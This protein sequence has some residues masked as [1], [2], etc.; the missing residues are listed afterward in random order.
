MTETEPQ[1]AIP[2][3]PHRV[4]DASHPFGPITIGAQLCAYCASAINN[5]AY[6]IRVE[7]AS[8][9]ESRGIP[10]QRTEIETGAARA[11]LAAGCWPD[12]FRVTGA[13]GEMLD[14][15]AITTVGG[16]SCCKWHLHD[17]IKNLRYRR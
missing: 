13:A 1:D 15:V 5:A 10:F 3:W 9:S 8:W 11:L 12:K 16:T 6:P 4:N 2:Q 17:E 14:V 7:S